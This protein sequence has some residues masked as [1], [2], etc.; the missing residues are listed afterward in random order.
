VQFVAVV[1]SI[2]IDRWLIKIGAIVFKG[3]FLCAD[4][5]DLFPLAAPIGKVLRLACSV[6]IRGFH[7]GR[8]KKHPPHKT[9]LRS[10]FAL[11]SFASPKAYYRHASFRLLPTQAHAIF[12]LRDVCACSATALRFN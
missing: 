11:F 6:A 1:K 10:S 12:V 8:K 4:H 7:A 9:W 3:I 2:F 5:A